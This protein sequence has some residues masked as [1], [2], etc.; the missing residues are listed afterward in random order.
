M[1]KV[2]KKVR[3]LARRKLRVR[4]DITGTPD[5]PRLSVRRSLKHIYAQLIDDS[6]GSTLASA[7]S[8]ALKIDGGNVDAAKEVGKALAETAKAKSIERVRFDRNGRLY[9]GRVKALADAAR[10]GGLR[11]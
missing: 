4:K 10:E 11:F 8:L 5:C 3:L 7:S 2:S 1:S 9:H 6:S